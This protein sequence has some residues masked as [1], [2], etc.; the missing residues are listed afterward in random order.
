MDR[1]KFE[2]QPPPAAIATPAP[3]P[4]LQTGL[5]GVKPCCGNCPNGKKHPVSIGIV[6]CVALP[7]TPLAMIDQAG[8]VAAQIVYPEMPA[9]KLGCNVFYGST[10]GMLAVMASAL[11]A[12]HDAVLEEPAD[13]EAG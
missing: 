5:P 9:D 7:P 3:V 13:D 8:H 2:D 10:P 6:Y 1:K 4:E 11:G 12:V